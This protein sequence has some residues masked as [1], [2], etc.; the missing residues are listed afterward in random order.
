M[1]TDQS[2]PLNACTMDAI[3]EHKEYALPRLG[4]DVNTTVFKT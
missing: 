4:H 2:M 3:L 1:V